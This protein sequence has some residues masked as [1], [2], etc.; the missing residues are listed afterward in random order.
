MIINCTPH[1][2]DVYAADAPGI[3][4]QGAMIVRPLLSIPPSGTVARISEQ[5]LRDGTPR[6]LRGAEA[7]GV[8]EV[9]YGHVS[10]L[11][12]VRDG[13]WLVV[14]LP[15]ALACPGRPDLLVPWRQ[16]RN[17]KGTTCGCRGLARPV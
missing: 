13:V 11:P 2:I 1:V 4:D 9:E 15:L 6:K 16:V 12:D 14:S 5:V 17:S 10:D 7:V 3:I 8:I